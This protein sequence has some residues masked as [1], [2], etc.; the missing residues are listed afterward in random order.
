MSQIGL[1]NELMLLWR[2]RNFGDEPGV[3]A[4][5]SFRRLWYQ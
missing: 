3:P 4:F 5:V 1:G 2:D